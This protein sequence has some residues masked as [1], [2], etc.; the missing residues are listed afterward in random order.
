M[1]EV[2]DD[3]LRD[4]CIVV[5]TALPVLAVAYYSGLR[6]DKI[7]DDE[8]LSKG[9]DWGIS[10]P[11]DSRWRRQPLRMMIE[12][13]VGGELEAEGEVEPKIRI[14]ED[15]RTGADRAFLVSFPL[16]L[17]LALIGLVTYWR[18]AI[19]A[20]VVF[21]LWTVGTIIAYSAEATIVRVELAKR[22][23]ESSQR[24]RAET[25][26]FVLLFTVAATS[27]ISVVVAI[28]LAVLL[29]WPSLRDLSAFAAIVIVGLLT[30]VLGIRSSKKPS[31]KASTRTGDSAE[32]VRPR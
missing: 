1:F 8:L 28:V 6:T 7:L 22:G 25:R 23:Q 18:W 9:P 14:G 13:S 24:A 10:V 31:K 21:V 19:G 26:P 12:L 30:W 11:V 27:T 16:G 32:G 15:F 29:A 4:L 20:S 3:Q 17:L 5:A 2:A